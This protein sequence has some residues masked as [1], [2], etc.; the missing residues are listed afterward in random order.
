MLKSKNEQI[1]HEMKKR[2]Q[3]GARV[4]QQMKKNVGEKSALKNVAF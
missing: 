1:M 3:E 4:K 2:E